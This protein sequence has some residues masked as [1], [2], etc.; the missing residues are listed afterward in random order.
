[1]TLPEETSN[2]RFIREVAECNGNPACIAIRQ[3]EHFA[4]ITAKN[5][6]DPLIVQEIQR[7]LAELSQ[8]F[9]RFVSLTEENREAM[10][11]H[12][13]HIDARLAQLVSPDEIRALQAQLRA[14][15]IS[16]E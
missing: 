16:D 15:G 12:L 3:A 11:E 8:R 10:R 2:D 13:A 4:R 9:G 1:M 7:E 5:Q 14:K 6:L